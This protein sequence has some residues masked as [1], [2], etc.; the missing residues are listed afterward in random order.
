MA[1]REPGEYS[2]V[3]WMRAIDVRCRLR[4]SLALVFGI[5]DW[6]WYGLNTR[7]PTNFHGI[8]VVMV[9]DFFRA[10]EIFILRKRGWYFC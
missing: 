4:F 7:K 8:F 5:W 1:K 6:C 3:V 10:D 2:K 9:K